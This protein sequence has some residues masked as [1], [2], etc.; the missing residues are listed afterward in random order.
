M[1][2][3]ILIDTQNVMYY[4]FVHVYVLSVNNF[5]FPS[6]YAFVEMD[7]GRMGTRGP[8]SPGM[9]SGSPLYRKM[10]IRIPDLGDPHSPVQS[11]TTKICIRSAYLQDFASLYLRFCD[12]L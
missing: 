3:T 9:G 4:T 10:G 6:V 7:N 11:A 8:H 12:S 5:S 2:D 1:T